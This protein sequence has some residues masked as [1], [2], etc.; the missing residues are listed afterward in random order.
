MDQARTAL[1]LQPSCF[2]D[3]RIL[4][5]ASPK[6]FTLPLLFFQ[7]ISVLGQRGVAKL[8]SFNP[9]RTADVT[10]PPGA[11][12]V[13]ANSLTRSNK[14]RASPSASGRFYPLRGTLGLTLASPSPAAQAET[15]STNYNFRVVECRLAAILTLIGSGAPA[16]EARKV[17]DCCSAFLFCELSVVSS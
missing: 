16:A 9:L 8:V 15:A 14:V 7:A 13:V 5:C 1:L 17:S 11:C 6:F 10:L 12:F 3:A 4:R 2:A